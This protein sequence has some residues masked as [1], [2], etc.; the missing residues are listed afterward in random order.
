MTTSTSTYI[1]G[2]QYVGEE[3]M[4]NSSFVLAR[5]PKRGT[6]FEMAESIDQP[7]GVHQFTQ[8]DNVF[9]RSSVTPW[10]IRRG[11]L[12]NLDPRYP[13]P[14]GYPVTQTAAP[15]AMC[16]RGT[17]AAPHDVSA[18]LAPPAYRHRV[19][20]LGVLIARRCQNYFLL[21][22]RTRIF[23]VPSSSPA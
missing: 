13:P 20:L 12:S 2:I 14:T 6:R 10:I 4:T 5:C 9:V 7:T 3:L 18:N 23:S 8:L 1:R 15:W 17:T 22:V 19:K 16:H 11:I 21:L